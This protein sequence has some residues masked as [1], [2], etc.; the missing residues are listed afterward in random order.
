MLKKYKNIEKF[1]LKLLT[2]EIISQMF[3][4]FLPEKS[5]ER[6]DTIISLAF[7]KLISLDIV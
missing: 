5:E 7:M 1:N 6:D 2:Q 3:L 4:V